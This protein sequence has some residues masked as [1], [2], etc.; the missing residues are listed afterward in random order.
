MVEADVKHKRIRWG[1]RS[2]ARINERIIPAIRD[3]PQDELA[4][5]ASQGGRAKAEAYA[6]K[7]NIPRC[8]G[9]YQALL[10]DSDVD[11]VYISLP[12]ALHAEWTIRAA[13]AGKHV[14]CEKPLALSVAE[15]DQM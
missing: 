14:L 8:Y 9:T 13:A 15:V 1:L 3:S 12:N 6:V 11:A 10:A 7:W 4:A 2:T 5:V